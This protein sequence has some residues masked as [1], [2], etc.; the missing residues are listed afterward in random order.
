MT[1]AGAQPRPGLRSAH[2]GSRLTCRFSLHAGEFHGFVE[3]D[4]S[5]LVVLVSEST[6]DDGNDEVDDKVDDE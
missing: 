6:D 2:V 1:K 4:V 5:G 3:L